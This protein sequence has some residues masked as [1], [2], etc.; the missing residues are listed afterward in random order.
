MI[1]LNIHGEMA[2]ARALAEHSGLVL[3]YEKDAVAPRTDGTNI[4]LP[5]PDVSWIQDE[6][7]LWRSFLYHEIGHN[8]PEMK[9]AMD[10]IKERGLNTATPFGFG[11]NVLEDYRQERFG[12]EQYE[13]KKKIM[14]RGREIFA[15]KHR[16]S[17]LWS[18]AGGDIMADMFR[19]LYIW[20]MDCRDDFMPNIRPYTLQALSV[21]PKEV[22]DYVKKLEKGGYKEKLNAVVT[23]KDEMK[24]LYDI[25]ENVYGLKPD[26]EKEKSERE[27]SDNTKNNNSKKNSKGQKDGEQEQ[28][29]TDSIVDWSDLIMHKHDDT[30]VGKTSY[31]KQHINYDTNWEKGGYQPYRDSE[32]VVVDYHNNV[33]YGNSDNYD[34]SLLYY[35]GEAYKD[36]YDVSE[37]NGLS[38]K[39]A[40]LLQIHSRDKYRYGKKRGTLHSKNLYRAGMK[41]AH[42]FNKRVFKQREINNCLD[43]SVTVLG[44]CS[45]S[46]GGSKFSSMGKSMVLLGRVLGDLNIQHELVGFT[47]TFGQLLYLYKPFSASKVSGSILANRVIS[48]SQI[49]AGNADAD[50]ILWCANRIRKEKSKRK[51]IIVLSDGCPAGGKSDCSLS[52]PD[53]L[54]KVTQEIE[55]SVDLEIYGIGIEDDNVKLFYKDN[56]VISNSDELDNALLSV[57]KTKIIG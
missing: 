30:I 9:D 13:G 2:H 17:T 45:G 48:S 40:R 28:E 52:Q 50:A 5:A 10:Y 51:I 35:K 14:A 24:L 37:G 57:I 27:T 19:S 3:K 33:L 47:D 18:H 7:D 26:V 44:D 22:V 54:S 8:V 53:F 34:D 31:N 32:T 29:K 6:W 41:D 1:N 4:Y 43:V 36:I 15:K 38:K 42:G 49:M 21:C 23:F 39:V 46:M 25:L 20:D 55:K 11:L 56:K 16:D 12:Y